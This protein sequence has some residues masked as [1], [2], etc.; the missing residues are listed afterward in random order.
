M[1]ISAANFE[2]QSLQWL[3]MQWLSYVLPSRMCM[4][5]TLIKQECLL[6][7]INHWLLVTEKII[8][9]PFQYGSKRKR[10]V[11]SISVQLH[12][13]LGSKMRPLM[14]THGEIRKLW[15]LIGSWNSARVN[16]STSLRI[17]QKCELQ[18]VGSHSPSE[19]EQ[20]QKLWSLHRSTLQRFPTEETGEQQNLQRRATM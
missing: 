11:V 18:M 3:P 1:I 7:M 19:E 9:L 14:V 16:I 13:D 20:E 17:N 4:H 10:S 2:I 8:S 6:G 12:S 15:W 5:R